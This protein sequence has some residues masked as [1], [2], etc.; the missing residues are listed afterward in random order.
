MSIRSLTASARISP[1]TA[2][3]GRRALVSVLGA[4]MTAMSVCSG[5]VVAVR[6]AEAQQIVYD[7]RAHV[8]TSLQA[9]RQLETLANQ[10]RQLANQ[11]RS[12]AASPY[13]H[14]AETSATLRDIGEL[15]STVRG[16]ASTI[17][18]VQRQFETLYPDNLSA[19][20]LLGLGAARTT[21][22]RRTAQDVARTT[23]E[24][25]RLTAGRDARLRGALAASE[26]AQGQTAAIQS[27]S[28]VLA[29][30]AEDLATMRATLLV[31]SRLM[32][33]ATARQAAERETAIEARRRFWGRTSATPTAPVFNPF[34][35]A[36]D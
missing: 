8:Q 28:Q 29:V 31:Q 22:A 26:G 18:G 12:L 35:H 19:T 10:A 11:A 13:S 30:L 24:L 7:P 23:A 14:L 21:H 6:P 2:P 4:V 33:E 20:D 36:L 1:I 34:T 25:Q 3:P 5:L 9:A 32:S 16:T 17:E 27:S 15:A